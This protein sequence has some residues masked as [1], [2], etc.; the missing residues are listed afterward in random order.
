MHTTNLISS[1]ALSIF[2]LAIPAALSASPA[3]QVGVA[4]SIR[5]GPPV[6]PV[7][8]QPLCPGPGYIWEPGYW[9]YG[10]EG[11]YWVSGIWVFPPQVG[12]LWT[13]GYWGFSN[14]FYVW[15]AGY[16]GPVVGFYGGINYGFG[17][18]GTGFY[19]GYWRGGQYF[20]NTRVTNVN[21]TIV[22]NVYTRNVVNEHGG[23]RV[24]FNGGPHGVSARPTPAQL[25]ARDRRVPM[26]SAQIQHQREASSNRTML[27]SVNH[28]RP[29]VAASSRPEAL[30]DRSAETHNRSTATERP[31]TSTPPAARP[32]PARPAPAS[33][34][35]PARTERTPERAPARTEK[36]AHEA[37][38]KRAKTEKPAAHESAAKPVRTEKPAHESAPKPAKTEK[39]A[40]HESAAKPP[41][42]EKP[43]H[44]SAP[45]PAKT[46]KPAHE[47]PIQRTGRSPESRNTTTPLIGGIL[48]PTSYCCAWSTQVVNKIL[49]QF[50]RTQIASSDAMW[51]LI[52]L[53]TRGDPAIYG[54]RL[55]NRC[56]ASRFETFSADDKQTSSGSSQLIDGPAIKI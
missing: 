23:N 11:Y 22:H 3:A 7:Y 55:G 27:A 26:T 33:K 25:S 52:G 9:S 39:P 49:E 37:A 43:A 32:A 44:E 36:P 21:T 28:G 30:N 4:V 20:Y 34:A 8:T 24:S 50:F 13:P 35:A 48:R 15:N 16:W 17:Y 18:P 42:T 31:R 46:E 45:K 10:A 1:L 53:K 51:K 41:R 6:L 5:I 47:Q 38:P 19:G 29:D 56:T 12:L 2:L 40:A 14:G 54:Q